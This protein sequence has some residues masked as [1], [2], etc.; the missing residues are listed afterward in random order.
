MFSKS[1]ERHDFI[2]GFMAVQAHCRTRMCHSVVATHMRGASVKPLPAAACRSI[3]AGNPSADMLF[4]AASCC[5]EGK[6]VASLMR[7]PA[8]CT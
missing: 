5:S 8:T 7:P 6:R 3:A 1:R 4:M 2:D